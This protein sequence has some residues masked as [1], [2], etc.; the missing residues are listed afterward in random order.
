MSAL[1]PGI[2]LLALDWECDGCRLIV[3]RPREEM[4]WD[5][6]PCPRCGGHLSVLL[7]QGMP[8]GPLLG[9]DAGR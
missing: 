2:E 1:P 9:E 6:D 4:P 7:I 8:R 3:E 5:T